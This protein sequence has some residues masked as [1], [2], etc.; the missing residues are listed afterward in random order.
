M[1]LNFCPI[2][3]GKSS[4]QVH[5]FSTQLFYYNEE[6]NSLFKSK[7]IESNYLKNYYNGNIGTYANYYKTDNKKTYFY[8]EYDEL[9]RLIYSYGKD[10]ARGDNSF[11]DESFTYDKMGN[12]LSKQNRMTLDEQ[13]LNYS[14]QGNRLIR[15]ENES[16]RSWRFRNQMFID[17]T[18]YHTE[19]KYDS[20][21]NLIFDE[22]K[23]ILRIEYN[24][25]NLPTAIQMKN[26]NQIRFSYD[27][28]GNKLSRTDIT[29]TDIVN[30]PLGSI[31]NI[32]SDKIRLQIERSYFG[33]IVYEQYSYPNRNIQEAPVIYR[34]MNDFGYFEDCSGGRGLDFGFVYYI[35]DHQG[36]V[37]TEINSNKSIKN[38]T[39]YFPS[40][41]ELDNSSFIEYAYNGKEKIETHGFNMYDY[42]ARFYDQTISRWHSMDP[43][44]EK[45]YSISPYV[46]CA[47]NPV[48][49][50]DPDGRKV[51]FAPGTSDDFKMQFG[52]AVKYLNET[53]NGGKLKELEDSKN[54]YYI[55]NGNT[56]TFNPKKKT[57]EWNPFEA[58]ITTNGYEM[59]PTE[60]LNHEIDHANQ[61]DKNPE[62]QNQDKKPDGSSYGNKEEKRVITGSEQKTAKNMGKLKEGE[63]TRT[64]HGGTPYETI[65]PVS[66][67][68]KNE[69]II[70]PLS[71]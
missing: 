56:G 21:G 23:G 54:I 60:V 34:I 27:A 22:N 39:S 29:R 46:Y 44:A 55:K 41:L 68:N 30:I 19:Y 61:N 9:D 33:N 11:Y 42:G 10:Q 18:D 45:Y 70:K 35:K 32:P 2:K 12:I 66:T 43:L 63:V 8:Y 4:W 71:H 59:S 64:D 37:K 62:K 3:V 58:I 47:N 65:S 6:Q 25:L 1:L 15:I 31:E 49:Y 20:N 14:Y 69:I 24:N 57:I 48:R 28:E 51:K 7:G 17:G 53:K 16:E 38:K 36:N 5:S 26:G 52:I 50:I 67:V 13:S 40:G